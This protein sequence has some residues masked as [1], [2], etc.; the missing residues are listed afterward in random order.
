MP[1]L[2]SES[3]G[4]NGKD[5]EHAGRAGGASSSPKEHQPSSGKQ[6]KKT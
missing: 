6:Y 2:L 3:K 1:G 5:N 4:G